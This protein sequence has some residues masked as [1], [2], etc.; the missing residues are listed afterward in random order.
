MT[1]NWKITLLLIASSF[2]FSTAYA[3]TVNEARTAEQQENYDD[4]IRAYRKLLATDTNENNYFSLGDA[5]LQNRMVDSAMY[6]FNQGLAEN[7]K[8]AINMVGLGKVKLMQDKPAEAEQHFND[9]LKRRRD[10]K[11]PTVLNEIARA[12][13]E[14]DAENLDKAIEHLNAS[15]ERDNKN[16]ETYLLLGEIYL[17]QNK[18][19]EAMNNY[20][21]ALR[22]DPNSARTHM[23]RGQLFVRSRNANEAEAAFKAAIAADPN[24][25]PIYRELGDLYL[26]VGKFDDAVENYK[27]NIELAGT[28]ALMEYKLATALFSAKR[29]DEANSRIQQALQE[30]PNNMGMQRL[31]AYAFYEAGENDKALE[32]MSA[33]IA[34]TDPDML[35]LDD[36]KYYGNML[37]KA[38]RNEEA[39]AMLRKAIELDEENAAALHDVIAMIHYRNKDYPKAVEEYQLKITKVEPDL[40]D[41]YRIGDSYYW[42]KEYQK[43][44]SLFSIIIDQ[45]SDYAPAHLYRARNNYFLDSLAQEGLAK[46]HYEKYIELEGENV[47]AT[48]MT[49]LIEAHSYL[50]AFYEDSKDTENATAHWQAVAELDPTNAAAAEALNSAGKKPA[51]RGGGTTPSGQ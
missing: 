15:L 5:Y 30:D 41:L 19:G 28:S 10:R 31:Q 12:Y 14:A 45:K 26:L 27:K 6:F 29:F 4:A 16:P 35:I 17:D 24:Y 48:N 20:E 33:Y 11:N 40:A 8:S 44:D 13:L 50:A 2:C 23:R 7:R 39:I 1:K 49:N 18:G 47:T 38:E 34:E 9:A 46:P 36:Y 42:M 51:A 25:A 43:S 37:A 21:Q 32:L 3:Q 22:L